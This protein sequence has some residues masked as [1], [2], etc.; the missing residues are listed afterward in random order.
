MSKTLTASEQADLLRYA[1]SLPKGSETR[2]AIVAAVSNVAAN[3]IG[4]DRLSGK[5]KG[6]SYVD[7]DLVVQVLEEDGWS[8]VKDKNIPTW[9]DLTNDGELFA[10]GIP[11][12][13]DKGRKA[14]R[15]LEQWQRQGWWPRPVKV[16][17]WKV[18][19]LH[20]PSRATFEAVF[21]T[22]RE[23]LAKATDAIPRLKGRK[24][25]AWLQPT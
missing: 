1:S 5:S 22:S 17:V 8:T 20:R 11:E 9:N 25:P 24:R 6:W 2:R 4:W 15:D 7:L 3:D 21:D 23:A 10:D 13:V 19:V 16:K 14:E 12:L 18:Y